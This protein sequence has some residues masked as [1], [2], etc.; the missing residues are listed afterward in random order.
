MLTR[1]ALFRVAGAALLL[2]AIGALGY[3]RGRVEEQGRDGP[4]WG[5][6]PQVGLDQARDFWFPKV[7]DCHTEKTVIQNQDGT[8]IRIVECECTSK[9]DD[10]A[11]LVMDGPCP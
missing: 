6:G 2:V 11:P 1:R 10:V 4:A 8:T 9:C 3:W 7:Y 5:R